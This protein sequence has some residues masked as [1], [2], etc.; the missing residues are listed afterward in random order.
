[1]KVTTIQ[2]GNVATDLPALSHNAAAIERHD[3]PSVARMLDPESF[4][5]GRSFTRFGN[6]ITSPSTR[7]Q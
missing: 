5:P 7:Y 1:L 4:V 2:P 3:Q 6:P